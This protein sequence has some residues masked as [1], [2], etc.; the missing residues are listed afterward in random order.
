MYLG[1]NTLMTVEAQPMVESQRLVDAAMATVRP[2]GELPDCPP[3]DCSQCPVRVVEKKVE[4]PGPIQTQIVYRDRYITSPG[5]VLPGTTVVQPGSTT[6]SPEAIVRIPAAAAPVDEFGAG[7]SAD[8]YA[9]F[10]AEGTEMAE[11]DM[12]THEVKKFP[13]LLLAA[14]GAAVWFLSRKK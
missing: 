9:A 2:S 7:G 13:W 5:S 6:L 4:V 1:Q 11:G 10:G 12:Q 14:G 8:Y 3:F